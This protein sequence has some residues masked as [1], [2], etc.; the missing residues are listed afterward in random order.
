MSAGEH[1]LMLGEFIQ[2]NI[3]RFTQLRWSIIFAENADDRYL[4]ITRTWE[5][6]VGVYDSQALDP[7]CKPRTF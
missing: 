7:H 6:L 2:E 5:N 3:A 4:G 1:I